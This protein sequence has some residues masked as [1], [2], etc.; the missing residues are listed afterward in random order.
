MDDGKFTQTREFLYNLRNAGSKYS[1]ARIKKLCRSLS[2]PQNAYPV[3]HVAG[4]NGKGSVCAMVESILRSRGLKTGMYTS[5][6]L[7]RLGERIQINRIP[8]EENEIVSETIRLKNISDTIFDPSDFSDY[9]SFFEF[10]TA[11]AFEMF[12]NRHVDCAVVEVGLGGRFDSTNIVHPRV[13]AITSIAFDHTELLG[14]TIEKIS[15]EKAGIIKS[16]V[17]VV[18]GFLPEKAMSVMEGEADGKGCPLYKVR[19]FFPDAD[20]LPKTSLAGNFQRRNAAVAAVV[21]KVLENSKP[22]L[23]PNLSKFIDRALGSVS[24]AA[25]W[26]KIPLA[27]G[28]T[29]I[30]DASHNEE[31]AESLEENL[32]SLELELGGKK[33]VVCVGSLARDRAKSILK[34]V[35]RHAAEIILMVPNQPRALGYGELKDCMGRISVPVRGSAVGD[36]FLPGGCREC[37]ES[38]TTIV[39]TGSIYLAG[40]ILAAIKAKTLDGLQDKP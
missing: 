18:C 6:H 27:N 29:L 37:V 35:S 4:T 34:V 9:P 25:R 22:A 31:G 17:P 23:F 36:M 21:A 32:A 8:V 24:W 19:D 3:I 30:L 1:L 13:C 39:S 5:P 33:P 11:M 12:A 40:E 28:I 14:D 16:G 15:R 10:M 20:S 38:G 26:Q 2:N 7:V